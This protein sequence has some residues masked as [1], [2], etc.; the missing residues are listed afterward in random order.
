MYIRNKRGKGRSRMF[1]GTTDTASSSSSS[2]DA[3]AGGSCDEWVSVSGTQELETVGLASV[4]AHK[5]RTRPPRLAARTRVLRLH[6]TALPPP[7][8]I[9][10]HRLPGVVWCGNPL[11]STSP[12]FLPVVAASSHSL[13]CAMMSVCVFR[14]VCVCMY[15]YSCVCVCVCVDEMY[16]YMYVCVCVFL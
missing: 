4:L 8:D 7:Q 15:M 13:P 2:G 9:P 11:F 12:L 14:Q 10:K 16:T 1:G 3:I 6:N 5:L